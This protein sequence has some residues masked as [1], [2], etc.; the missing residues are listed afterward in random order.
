MTTVNP[1][2]WR[3]FDEGLA[4]AALVGSD[5]FFIPGP[6]FRESHDRLLVLHQ[7]QLWAEDHGAQ[8]EAERAVVDAVESLLRARDIREAIDTVWSVVILERE[9]RGAL[10]ISRDRLRELVKQVV[11]VSGYPRIEDAQ[12]KA[13][14]QA[15][16]DALEK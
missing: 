4:S 15:V 16:L 5:Q 9:Y 10:P 13:V 12:S 11:Q 14:L 6:T 8:A 1:R 7:L 2:L 3:Y